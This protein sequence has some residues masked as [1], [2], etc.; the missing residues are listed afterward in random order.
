MVT[1]AVE[2]V[3]ATSRAATGGPT[4]YVVVGNGWRAGF[5]LRLAGLFPDRLQVSAIVTQTEELGRAAEEQWG[6]PSV[7]TV[8]DAVVGDRPDFVV[9]AVPWSASPQISRE[10]VA[11]D[12][13]VLSET[14]PAPDV[15]GLVELW[16]QV[17]ASGLVQVAEQYPLYP[18]HAARLRLIEDGVLGTISNVQV[19]STHQY[20]AVALMR[21][22]LGVRF[23]DAV[24]TAHHSE[25]MLA[26]PISRDGWTLDLSPK[27]AWNL[28]AH[29]DFGDGRTGLYDFTDNQW[30]NELRS[31]RILVR[32]SLGELV[33]DRVVHVR[34]EL[35]VLESDLVRRQTGVDMNFE[36]F[37]L[38][39]ISFEGDVVYRNPWRGGRLADDEIAVATLLQKMGVWARDEGPAPYPLADACQDHM[40]ALAMD[41]SLAAGGA[42]RTAR[43]PWAS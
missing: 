29:F 35:S 31:N 10:A 5:Y 36:G 21:A 22:M 14:P 42:V 9:A 40:L 15:P 20:H 11:L 16:S 24:V 38:D 30:H 27:P 2:R 33:T 4:R 19:S 1:S 23:E 41:E 13:P 43:Q 8:K 6:A 3:D 26:D 34:D 18:G 32:G 7:R 37:D 39:H 28:L 17:G 25:F 12:M